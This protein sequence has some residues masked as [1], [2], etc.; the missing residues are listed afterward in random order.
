MH[1]GDN[2]FGAVA[3]DKSFILG[4]TDLIYSLFF[5][6]LS[7][8]NFRTNNSLNLYWL[9][10]CDSFP[11]GDSIKTNLS[12]ILQGAIL[13]GYLNFLEGKHTLVSNP[14]SELNNFNLCFLSFFFFV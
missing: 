2:I 11:S 1:K 12:S 14:C 5:L 9:A 4:L 3:E 10:L 8:K 6:E 13:V 7:N